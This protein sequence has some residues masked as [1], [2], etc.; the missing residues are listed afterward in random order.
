[1]GHSWQIHYEWYM[2]CSLIPGTPCMGLFTYTLPGSS[3]GL[4]V[5]K[6][7]YFGINLPLYSAPQSLF[8][9]ILGVGSQGTGSWNPFG[10][11]RTC[12][13]K[14]KFKYPGMKICVSN[15]L[16]FIF[17]TWKKNYLLQRSQ[18]GRKLRSLFLGAASASSPVAYR[19]PL[20]TLLK[21][22]THLKN[23]HQKKDRD[24]TMCI[25]KF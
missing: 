11:V 3:G 12:R 16:G 1:M 8:H 15:H 4:N 25:Q 20:Y 9:A 24:T 17:H 6:Y 7:H 10:L 23:V 5:G 19:S 18:V 14:N 2:W 13:K 21:K 22:K